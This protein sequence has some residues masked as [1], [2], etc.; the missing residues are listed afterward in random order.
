VF[1]SISTVSYAG[2]S[3]NSDSTPDKISNLLGTA[4][5][6]KSKPPK[7]ILPKQKFVYL[8]GFIV[9]LKN[10]YKKDKVLISDVILELND[11]ENFPENKVNRVCPHD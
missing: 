3:G 6:E 4:K 7:I 1:F 2:I 11:K 5:K 10:N 9:H 8:N